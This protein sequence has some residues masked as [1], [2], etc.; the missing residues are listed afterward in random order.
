MKHKDS[1]AGN[2]FFIILI[3]IAL[4]AVFGMVVT[5]SSS[6]DTGATN[7]RD[8]IAATSIIQYGNV[9]KGA[10]DQMRSN[11]ISESD[12]SFSNNIVSGYGTVGANPSAEVFNVSGGGIT[13]EAPNASW[14]DSTYSAQ[15]GYGQ[16]IFNGVNAGRLNVGTPAGTAAFCP[17][18]S[19]VELTLILPY[20]KKSIC[21][22]ISKR[23][24]LLSGGNPIQDANTISFTKFTGTF[25]YNG[26]F[27]GD[28][29]GLMNST[30][31][32][33]VEGGG[34]PAA[35]TYHYF[36]VLIAR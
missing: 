11:G 31:E 3:G 10:I 33:C 20:V 34:T 23:F 35:G 19:C 15:T 6:T 8:K 5:R 29:A 21:T 24:N 17:T 1:Q 36:K 4:L 16:W 22:E 26:E 27:I 30:Y 2:A 7:E 28:A 18:A 25:S 13:Y 32:G 12:I 9:V 14:L